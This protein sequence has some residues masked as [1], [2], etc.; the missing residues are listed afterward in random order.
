MTDTD[1]TQAEPRALD[2]AALSI[3]EAAR[4]LAMAKEHGETC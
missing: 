1:L 3:T 4:A 2:P